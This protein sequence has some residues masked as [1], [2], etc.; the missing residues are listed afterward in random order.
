MLMLLLHA[1]STAINLCLA[2]AS[3]TR[4]PLVSRR[5]RDDV[6]TLIVDEHLPLHVLQT[7][8]CGLAWEDEIAIANVNWRKEK[9]N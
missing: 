8:V 4:V 6:S 1:S 9:D 5:D 2:R 3:F 7:Q